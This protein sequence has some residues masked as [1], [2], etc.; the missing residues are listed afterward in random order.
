MLNEEPPGLD[1]RPGVLSETIGLSPGSKSLDLAGCSLRKLKSSKSDLFDF[2]TMT[3]LHRTRN[4][5]E[6]G[7]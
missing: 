5:L 1:R 2:I 6:G 3:V 4:I 7:T